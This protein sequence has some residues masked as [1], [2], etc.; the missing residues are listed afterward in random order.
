MGAKGRR[1]SVECDPD[2][3]VDLVHAQA[4]ECSARAWGIVDLMKDWKRIAEAYGIPLTA[5]ELDRITPPLAALEET[6][7]PLVQELTPDVEPA[8]ELHLDGDLS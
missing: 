2:R 5:H 7:R 1:W 8:L 6:F 3:R 4:A